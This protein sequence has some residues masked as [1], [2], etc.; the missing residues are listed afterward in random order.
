MVEIRKLQLKVEEFKPEPALRQKCVD[1]L[2]DGH[3]VLH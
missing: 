1:I 3:G 2:Y